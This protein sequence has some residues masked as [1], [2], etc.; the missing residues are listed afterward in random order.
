MTGLHPDTGLPGDV[1]AWNARRALHPG[2]R[3]AL[4]GAD[5]SGRRLDGI[6]LSGADLQGASLSGAWLRGADLRKADLTGADLRLAVLGGAVLDGA[7]LDGAK[8]W[9]SRYDR[10]SITG[11]RC[12]A[13]A[14]D[15][16]GGTMLP[17]DEGEFQAIHARAPALQL[18]VDGEDVRVEGE[19]WHY[20]AMTMAKGGHLA[21]VLDR[22]SATLQLPPEAGTAS[23]VGEAAALRK[24]V[25][26]LLEQRREQEGERTRMA[27]RMLNLLF[28]RGL[29]DEADL[30]RLV[31]RT[32]LATDIKAFSSLDR[33]GQS[34]AAATLDGVGALLF[35]RYGAE[36]ANDWGDALVAIF[37]SPNDACAAALGLVA[38]M[39]A[40]GLSIRVGLSTGMLRRVRKAVQGRIGFE[41]EPL[42]EAA[43]L[44]PVAG[45]GEVIAAP[46]AA[47]ALEPAP[48]H[49]AVTP[50]ERVWTKSFGTVQ[51]GDPAHVF[52]VK[53]ASAA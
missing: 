36:Y 1:P 43:R 5:L 34:N 20:I 23:S 28:K 3:P 11:V 47:H 26:G 50:V 30:G 4:A 19:E 37:A 46:S 49:F 29:L 8:L 10:W 18:S 27:E 40:G 13:A 51:A 2:D 6:D 25:D 42:V 32:V 12:A 15:E 45:P 48:Q 41:G 31:E 14:W 53:P 21:L 35:D 52:L 39:K 38:H 33:P 22:A 9:G 7:I 16:A 24:R 17:Y 44:E